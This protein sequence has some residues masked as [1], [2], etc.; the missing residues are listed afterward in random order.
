MTEEE[1]KTIEITITYGGDEG[2]TKFEECK[3]ALE[4]KYGDK[5]TVTGEESD[6]DKF[7]IKCNG[8]VIHDEGPPTEEQMEEIYTKIDAASGSAGGSAAASGGASGGGSAGGND[9]EPA[10]GWSG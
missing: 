4:E 1:N 7:E 5:I 3:T 6:E 10:G 8:E 2:A 9:E